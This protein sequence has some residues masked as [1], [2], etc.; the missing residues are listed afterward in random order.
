MRAV[1]QRVTSA[2]VQVDENTIGEIG[3]GLLILLGVSREDA[4][5]DASWLAEKVATLRIFRDSEG[6]MNLSIKEAGGSAL[7]VSQFTLMGDSRKGR[8]P[9]FD[10]AASPEQAERLYERFVE[11]L[12]AELGPDLEVATGSFGAYMSVSLVNDG[13]VTLILDSRRSF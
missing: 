7:V 1:L 13:P 12:R 8:R 2:R 3:K 10:K 5:P 6:R 11:L 4:E 9:S